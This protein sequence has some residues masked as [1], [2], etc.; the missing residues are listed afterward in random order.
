MRQTVKTF[1]TS[2]RTA[3]TFSEVLTLKV[4]YTPF[5]KV[6]FSSAHPVVVKTSRYDITTAHIDGKFITL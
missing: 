6:G 4:P 2:I 1:E 5:R 3:P